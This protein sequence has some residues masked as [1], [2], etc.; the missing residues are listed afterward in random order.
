MASIDKSQGRRR[1]WPLVFSASYAALV[2]GSAADP[3]QDILCYTHPDVRRRNAPTNATNKV[4]G[5]L[6]NN[7]MV[8]GQ[9]A[10]VSGGSGNTVG[11]AT[12]NA[13]LRLNAYRLGVLQGCIAYYS[14]SVNTAIGTAIAAAGATQVVTP[15]AMTNIV[16]GMALGIGSGSTFEVVYA[17]SVTSTTF[18]ADYVYAHANTDA[19]TSIL[20]PFQ[21]VAWVPTLAASTT[22]STAVSAAGSHAIT[23][24]SIYGIHVGDSL[25]ITGGTG[26]AETV[27]VTAVTATTFTATFANTHS[28]TYD[29]ATAATTIGNTTTVSNEPFVLQGGD[30]AAVERL[31]NNVTG[32]ATPVGQVMLELL[33]AG[34]GQ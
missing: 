18:T 23:P 25:A 15:T 22:S 5:S 33:P 4:T 29:I 17:Y 1:D 13:D 8:V 21:P 12:N 11:N 20:V 6:P 9:V 10:F 19:V 34:I 30:V 28:G 3:A 14:L 27:V 32:I 7:R 16:N 26:T 31:S 2:A 24:A